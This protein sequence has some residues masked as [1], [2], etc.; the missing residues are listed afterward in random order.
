MSGCEEK[1]LFNPI[2]GTCKR[3]FAPFDTIF[4][5]DVN[6]LPVIAHNELDAIV[7]ITYWR[8]VNHKKQPPWRLCKTQ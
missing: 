4:K 8:Q 6:M 7:L 3:D 1:K 5:D 2:H